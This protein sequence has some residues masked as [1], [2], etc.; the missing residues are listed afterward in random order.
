[1][2]PVAKTR[3]AGHR[4]DVC[5][6]GDSRGGAAP[7]SDDDC[8][9]AHP[10]LDHVLAQRHHLER[11][12]VQTDPHHAVHHGDRGRHRA[13]GPDGTL[14]VAGHP[15]VARPRQ[16]V[17]DDGRLERHD[18][19]ALCQRGPHLVGDLQGSRNGLRRKGH[20]PQSTGR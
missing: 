9:V 20:A 15:E 16:A 6:R 17:A 10:G 8:Q 12:V 3:D 7:A 19:R 11:C 18:R 4:R 5:G 14:D 2:P 13:L 1:M